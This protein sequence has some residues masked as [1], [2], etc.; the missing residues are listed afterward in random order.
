MLTI[1]SERTLGPDPSRFSVTRKD[2]PVSEVNIRT[3]LGRGTFR[4]KVPILLEKSA[5][6]DSG[7]HPWQYIRDRLRMRQSE[8]VTQVG[9]FRI[10]PG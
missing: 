10:S 6:F 5:A 8:F 7:T 9:H 3:A 4:S 2:V 1:V